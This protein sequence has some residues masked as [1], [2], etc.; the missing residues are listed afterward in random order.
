MTIEDSA[1]ATARGALPCW[2]HRPGGSGIYEERAVIKVPS[3]CPCNGTGLRRDWLRA[4]PTM[5]PGD[6]DEPCPEC[7]ER[8][9]WEREDE[10]DAKPGRQG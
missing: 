1:R 6:E 7:D 9:D 5:P 2:E 4:Y 8:G 3:G 10:D